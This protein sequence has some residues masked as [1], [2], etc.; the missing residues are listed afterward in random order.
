MPLPHHYYYY[1]YSLTHLHTLRDYLVQ[2][3]FLLRPGGRAFF[4]TANMLS[5]S[6][7]ERFAAQRKFSVAG[8]AFVCPDMVRKLVANAGLVIVEEGRPGVPPG[9]PDHN[10]YYDR[11]YLVVV[12]RPE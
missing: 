4:S 3:A 1:S 12:E 2:L 5:N 9:H 7:W 6:G 8:F 11:D 10:V